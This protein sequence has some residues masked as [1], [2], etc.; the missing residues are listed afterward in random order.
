MKRMRMAI[1]GMGMVLANALSAQS[2]V[3]PFHL[4]EATIGDVHAAYMSGAL[5][6]SK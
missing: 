1:A 2:V 5:T 3:K 4:D 6:A